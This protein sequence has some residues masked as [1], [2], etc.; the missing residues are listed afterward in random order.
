MGG[1]LGEAAD[2]KTAY[3]TG[4]YFSDVTAKEKL[5]SNKIW[6]VSADHHC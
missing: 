5:T 4:C 1:G 3:A 6:A 2:D